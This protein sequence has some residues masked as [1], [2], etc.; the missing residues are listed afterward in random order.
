MDDVERLDGRLDVT[1]VD[2]VNEIGKET[3]GGNVTVAATLTDVEKATVRVDAKLPVRLPTPDV[4]LGL[5]AP[6]KLDNLELNDSDKD[7]GKKETEEREV[8]TPKVDSVAS[9]E[10]V[11]SVADVGN[12]VDLGRNTRR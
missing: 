4:R 7:E 9:G 10:V 11:G 12:P 2:G 8:G 6:F 3:L 5:N 1:K